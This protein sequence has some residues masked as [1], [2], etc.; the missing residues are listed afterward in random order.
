MCCLLLTCHDL[1]LGNSSYD[2]TIGKWQYELFCTR[3]RRVFQ[4]S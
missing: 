1:G 2:R 3:A 4:D